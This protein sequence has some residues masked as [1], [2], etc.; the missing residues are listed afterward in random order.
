[1]NEKQKFIFWSTTA[2]KNDLLQLYYNTIVI[3]LLE[4][5]VN[6]KAKLPFEANL[7]NFN[8][9]NTKLISGQ[10]WIF[11]NLVS[12]VIEYKETTTFHLFKIFNVWVTYLF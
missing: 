12:G 6:S 7:I 5:R 2:V 9:F 3:Q 11:L 8:N 10:L 1:M 4:L